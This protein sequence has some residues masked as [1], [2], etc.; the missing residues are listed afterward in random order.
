MKRRILAAFGTFAVAVSVVFGVNYIV[1]QKPMV[2]V[3]KTDPRNKGVVISAHYGSYIN[4]SELVFDLKSISDLNSP[5]DVSR[6]LLQYADALKEKKFEQVVL[7]YKGKHK[8][9]LKGGYFK[10]LG[11]DYKTQN[12]V[13]TMRTFPEN[14]YRIDGTAAFNTW[15]GGL[16]SVLGKQMEEFSEFHKQWYLLEIA[17]GS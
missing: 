9:Q 13:Y 3:L 7:A 6:V 12:P 14:V 16:L 5:A 8:F 10:T 1:L 17:G 15:A 11:M 2:D 4:P